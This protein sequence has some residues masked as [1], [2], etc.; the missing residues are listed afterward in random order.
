MKINEVV[1]EGI[2]GSIGRGIAAMAGVKTNPTEL[3][4]GQ[5]AAQT[6]K[7]VARS[8]YDNFIKE[9]KGQGLDIKN[10]GATMTATVTDFLKNYAIDF[11]SG[12][13][14]GNEQ[15]QVA[16]AVAKIPLPTVINPT[17][18]QEYFLASA[19]ARAEQLQPKTSLRSTP[20]PA[21]VPEPNATPTPTKSALPPN[22][23]VLTTN[24]LTIKVNK[25]VYELDDMDQW[26]PLGSSKTVT[27]GQAAILNKYLGMI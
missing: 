9:L 22:V 5:E 18:V 10:V 17:T 13:H 6:I 11:M 15:L 2:L 7:P 19:Q 1:T 14:R 25:Q 12:G 21:A 24:P 8:G 27:P 23:Q 26:H 20:S 4:A 3:T 16:S